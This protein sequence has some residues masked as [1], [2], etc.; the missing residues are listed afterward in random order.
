MDLKFVDRVI[1]TTLLF[2]A[3]LFPFLAVYYRLNFALSVL[4]GAAWGSLNLLG[5]KIIITSLISPEK[6]DLKVGLSILFLKFP[7]LY[8][9]GYLM[10]SWKYLSPGGLLFGFSIILI[11]AVLK[12][13]SRSLLGLD[14][15]DGQ[16]KL[17]FPAENKA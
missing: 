3:F 5:I 16:H 15:R 1:K 13:I 12:V 2:S 4:F 17:G 14:K 11:V 9:L 8:I 10:L 7:V 6:P